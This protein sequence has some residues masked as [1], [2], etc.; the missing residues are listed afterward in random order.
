MP[1]TYSNSEELKNLVAK[2]KTLESGDIL[3]WPEGIGCLPYRVTII[4]LTPSLEN[5]STNFQCK[6]DQIFSVLNI[7]NRV[8]FC[9]DL[10]GYKPDSNWLL[11]TPHEGDSMALIRLAI[12]L[13]QKAEILK[14]EISL[15]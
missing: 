1:K 15:E 7:R 13:M 6:D 9:K 12:G 4:G 8:K 14:E 10:Y 11:P 2:G 3:K 5:T